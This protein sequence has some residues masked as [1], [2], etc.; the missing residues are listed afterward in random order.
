MSLKFDIFTKLVVIYDLLCLERTS[1]FKSDLQRP[2]KMCAN[3]FD[4]I[5][6]LYARN[7]LE[8]FSFRELLRKGGIFQR[9][10]WLF[11]V[12]FWVYSCYKMA[13]FIECDHFWSIV[14]CPKF[15]IFVKSEG[16]FFWQGI[17]RFL[18]FKQGQQRPCMRCAKNDEICILNVRNEH[19]KFELLRKGEAIVFWWLLGSSKL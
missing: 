15:E 11:Q 17:E 7:G 14:V 8:I 12:C 4:E 10:S 13:I 18:G 9:S 6:I 5:H 19:M 3:I 16:I 1:G 2:V